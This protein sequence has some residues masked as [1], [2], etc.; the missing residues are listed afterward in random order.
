MVRE[1]LLKELTNLSS[2]ERILLA[3]D[4]WDS[5]ADDP[6]AWTLSP[7][8]RRELD[9]RLRAFRGRVA[10]GQSAGSSWPAVKRRVRRRK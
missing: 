6:E 1:T 8:Q 3:Q 2:S 9:R 10:R 7:T 5:V 4:L